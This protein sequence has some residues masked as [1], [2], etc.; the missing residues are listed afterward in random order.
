MCESVQNVFLALNAWKRITC[1]E[2]KLHGRPGGICT[3]YESTIAM[4][5]LFR[6]ASAITF[7]PQ[8]NS[9]LL[10]KTLR[11]LPASLQT[12]SRTHSHMNNSGEDQEEL[13]ETILFTLLRKRAQTQTG[14]HY[15]LDASSEI[16]A[17]AHYFVERSSSS[18]KR[19]HNAKHKR[20]DGHED[21]YHTHATPE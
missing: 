2:L 10:A 12:F 9:I 1:L 20:N 18:N 13:R 19:T 5:L 7:S 11:Y 8:C 3:C 6:L 21:K 15:R 4:N 17:L 14:L 16:N